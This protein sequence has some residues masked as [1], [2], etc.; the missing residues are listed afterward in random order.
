MEN[1]VN[2]KMDA[3]NLSS[4]KIICDFN[5][6]F[7]ILLRYWIKDKGPI[8]ETHIGFI[9]SY[10]DPSSARAE[11]SAFVG[12]LNKDMTKK[13]DHLIADATK[14]LSELPWSA[15]F[16]KDKFLKPD[17]TSMDVLSFTGCMLPAGVNIPAC[18]F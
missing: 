5:S 14:Y 13:L 12:M 17:F 1:L 3:G 10:R 9:F 11:F 2:I 18:E 16:E 15:E 7:L 4:S 8:I 6:F